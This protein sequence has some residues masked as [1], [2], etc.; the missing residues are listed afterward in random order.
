M[1]II[2][3]LTHVFIP[4]QTL[5]SVLYMY[6]F[7]LKKNKSLKGDITIIFYSEGNKAQKG[8]VN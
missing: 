5:F 1:M 4:Y 6:Y 8:L 3:Q 2:I 7:T